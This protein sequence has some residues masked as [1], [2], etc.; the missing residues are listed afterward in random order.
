MKIV[1][2]GNEIEKNY[3]A[4]ILQLVAFLVMLFFIIAL[5]QF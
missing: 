1:M 2:M 5:M 4:S 3:I